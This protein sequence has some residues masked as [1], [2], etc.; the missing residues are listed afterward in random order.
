MT[1]SPFSN[2]NPSFVNKPS[3]YANQIAAEWRKETR[4]AFSF[5]TKY[6][7]CQS[8]CFENRVLSEIKRKF[9]VSGV[10]V[11]SINPTAQHTTSF[12]RSKSVIL[13]FKNTGKLWKWEVVCLAHIIYSD[14]LRIF[15]LFRTHCRHRS[16][17]SVFFNGH[18]VYNGISKERKRTVLTMGTVVKNLYHLYQDRMEHVM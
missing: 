18:T 15:V 7:V 4:I 3:V 5:E 17:Y 8:T 14:L 13:T 16:T 6:T 1:I 2:K 12:Q 11:S 10:T 9:C